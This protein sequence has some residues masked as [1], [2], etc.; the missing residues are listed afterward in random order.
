MV[1]KGD[2]KVQRVA[3]TGTITEYQHTQGGI[4]GGMD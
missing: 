4:N 2:T 3:N 1:Q